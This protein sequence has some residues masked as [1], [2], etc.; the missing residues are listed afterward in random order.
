MIPISAHFVVQI[1]SHAAMLKLALAKQ[2]GLNPFQFLTLILV[3]SNER[4]STKE[5]KQKLSIPGSSLTFT[6]DSL[7]RKRLIKRQRSKEDRRQWFLSLT[8]KGK[9]LYD[10]ILETEGEVVL[11][12][13]D[14]L[15]ETEKTIFLKL[16]EDLI[17]TRS[18]K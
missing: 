7:E 14:K 15:S 11:P 12:A 18:A 3:G 1:L 6:I 13:L 8:A 2:F 9:Q 16:A 4:I 5:L 10:E 17:N